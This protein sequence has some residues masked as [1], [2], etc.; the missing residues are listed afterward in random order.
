VLKRQPKKL[1]KV[2]KNCLAAV[3]ADAEE[4]EDGDCSSK[5]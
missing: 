5:M 4:E 3:D 1:A 2:L